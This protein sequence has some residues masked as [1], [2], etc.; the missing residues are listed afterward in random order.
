[1]LANDF[2]NFRRWIFDHPEI[3]A[4]LRSIHET[5]AF[6]ATVEQI[7]I[8]HGFPITRQQV[9]AAMQAGRAA[10]LQRWMWW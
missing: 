5:E 6:M 10:W 8:D 3:Q 7:A 9:E 2:E 4:Q 1:M